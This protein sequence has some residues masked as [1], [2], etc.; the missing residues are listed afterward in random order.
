MAA[1]PQNQPLSSKSPN[2]PGIPFRSTS[3]NYIN[4][5]QNSPTSPKTSKAEEFRT[6][7][8][9]IPD[10]RRNSLGEI[11]PSPTE[12]WKP[13]FQRTQSWCQE[14]LKRQLLE[15]EFGKQREQGQ[16]TGFT[17]GGEGSRKV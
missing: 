17:E 16:G 6:Q 15:N 12:S 9:R 8:V 1:Q 2:H 14:D 11:I 5:Q 10:G 4:A 3:Q 7:A 13:N